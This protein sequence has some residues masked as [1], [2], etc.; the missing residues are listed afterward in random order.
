MSKLMIYQ[1]WILPF[2]GR[3]SSL[4]PIVNF[5]YRDRGAYVS[6]NHLAAAWCWLKQP[7]TLERHSILH[8]D[9]HYD[10]RGAD[11]GAHLDV[12]T[13]RRMDFVCY[14]S[15]PHPND[16]KVPIFTWD[17]YLSIYHHLNRGNIEEV[18]FST[19]EIGAPPNFDHKVVDPDRLID[20]VDS[21]EDGRNWIFNLD[22]DFFASPEG[23][24]FPEGRRSDLYEALAGAM[25]R[26]AN[27]ALTIALSPECTGSWEASE[28]L[29]AECSKHLGLEIALPAP[30]AKG[31]KEG[32]I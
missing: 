18:V 25:R 19:H 8:I 5:L 31:E 2:R 4:G 20:R 17:N 15:L 7:F 3:N 28:K 11:A 22:L 32:N 29:L 13:L 9:A 21:I 6:D 14:Q 27:Y 16:N 23:P 12:Q 24:R 1:E 26:S 10:T 30:I